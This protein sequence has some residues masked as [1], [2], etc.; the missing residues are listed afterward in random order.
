[1]RKGLIAA[2]L[3]ALVAVAVVTAAV[4][5][6]AAQ[7]TPAQ[8]AACTNVSLGFLG[9]LT[10]PAGFLGQEQLSWLRFGV[11]KYNKENGTRFKVVLG[12]TQLKAPVARTQ[13]RRFTGNSNVM[14]VIGGSES[15]AV[16]V[17]GKLFA[18]ANLASVSGSATAVDLTKGRPFRTF[19]RVVPND[20]IQ[21]PDIV[22]YVSRNLRASDV[23]VIDSQ[24]DYSV[25]LSSAVTRGLR[26][27]NVE[28][29][30]ESVSADDTDFSSIVANVGSEVDVVI[31][32]TQVAT[33]A[34][35]L[36]NQLREQG[37]KAIVFGTDG[38]YSPSQFKPRSGYVSVF[39]PDLHFDPAARAIIRE[40]RRFVSKDTSGA[41]GPATYM[42]GWVAMNAISR[43]CAN[44]SATRAEVVQ[45]TRRTSVPSIIGPRIAFDAKGDLKGG[46]A[47]VIYKIANGKYSP[48]G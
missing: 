2:G 19:F 18:N 30:R 11:Q 10:G 39:A 20:G 15:Q 33:A 14:A 29:G 16:R 17:S 41:F 22:N 12:D 8:I 6:P 23:V 25:P 43:A 48:V 47:F 46:G 38:A 9:P 40:Y 3:A 45:M 34:N 5:K 35:T 26:A 31:F 24:D 44:G 7:T 42:A 1:M 37:K 27:R 28:V 32:A 4:A 13:A 36:S 21:G